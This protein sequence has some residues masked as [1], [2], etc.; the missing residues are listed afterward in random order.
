M[1]IQLFSLQL[2]D[3]TSLL[4]LGFGLGVGVGIGVGILLRFHQYLQIGQNQNH[5]NHRKLLQVRQNC[6]TSDS[7]HP[8][9]R[10]P[11]YQSFEIHLLKIQSQ[12]M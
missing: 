4:G 1:F 5:S 8:S 10:F 2:W 11:G 3:L 6:S 9:Q 12:L 7:N